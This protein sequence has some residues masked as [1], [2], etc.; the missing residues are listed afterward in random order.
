MAGALLIIQSFKIMLGSKSARESCFK[1]SDVDS[2]IICAFKKLNR[3]EP[4]FEPTPPPS[5]PVCPSHHQQLLL[6]TSLV[7]EV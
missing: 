1:I 3:N 7:L 6:M 4:H 5:S 2:R